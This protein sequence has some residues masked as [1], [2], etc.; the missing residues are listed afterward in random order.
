MRATRATPV[1]AYRLTTVPDSLSRNR[2]RVSP[3]NTYSYTAMS[4]ASV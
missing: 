4:A 3:S 2:A 1:I